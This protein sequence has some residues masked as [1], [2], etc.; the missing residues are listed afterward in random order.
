MP[1]RIQ[2]KRTRGWRMPEGAVYVGRPSKWGDCMARTSPVGAPSTSRATPTCSSRSRTRR[3]WP[4]VADH[5][6]RAAAAALVAGAVGAHAGRED[7]IATLLVVAA[8]AAGLADITVRAMAE[9]RAGRRGSP[10]A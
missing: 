1:E 9:V 7:A 4:T 8:C 5:K 3:R 6:L 2:R 10:H